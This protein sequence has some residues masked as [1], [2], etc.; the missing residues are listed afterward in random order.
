[1][2][3]CNEAVVILV[4]FCVTGTLTKGQGHRTNNGQVGLSRHKTGIIYFV[5]F[6]SETWSQIVAVE[7]DIVPDSSSGNR[8]SSRWLQW[9][10][11]EVLDKIENIGCSKGFNIV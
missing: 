3:L 7:T 4:I 9:K 2:S 5:C 8:Y 6:C 10:C 11:W 1:M